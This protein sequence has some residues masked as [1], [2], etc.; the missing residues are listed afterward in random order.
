MLQ[1]VWYGEAPMKRR[2]LIALFGSAVALWPVFVSAQQVQPT[3][4]IGFLY[5]GPA[6]A[7]T[8]RITAL[9][10]G[11]RSGHVNPDEI[12]VLPA[13]SAG[14]DSL[15]PQLAADLVARKVDLI[16]AVSPPA[17]RA[18]KA[19]TST[20]PIVVSDLET[21]PVR[22]GFVQTNARPGG[23]ITGL[24]LDFPDF[25]GKWLELLHETIP[26]LGRVA[27][28]WNPT[29]GMVQLQAVEKAARSSNIKLEIIKV[30]SRPD[31]EPA[32]RSAVEHQAQGVLMLPSAAVG[33]SSKLLADLSLANGMPAISIFTDFPRAGG[34]IAYGPNLLD[35]F[36]QQGV[37][38]AKILQGQKPAEL[39][40]ET[41]TRFE[42]VV[43]VKTAKAL[44]LDLPALLQQRADEVIE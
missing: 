43:N 24:F 4:R 37:L 31:F 21:D 19:A 44:G 13:A 22:E 14:N 8:P 6:A 11:V 12:Q 29:S 7:A 34:L 39:P 26:K 35:F 42:L 15:L 23:N 30:E 25:A 5:P 18:A 36:Q 41:P 33:S 28:F 40:T 2:T 32:F 3:R 27:V 17:I 10:A 9:M 1:K 38:V 20:I 16:L